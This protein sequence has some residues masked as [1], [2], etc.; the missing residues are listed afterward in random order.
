MNQAY[1]PLMKFA[2]HYYRLFKPL[3][4]FLMGTFRK[5]LL[6]ASYRRFGIRVSKDINFE[7]LI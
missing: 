7:S 3:C 1:T 5:L 4:P 2:N 6:M